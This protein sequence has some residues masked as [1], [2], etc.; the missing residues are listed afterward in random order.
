MFRKRTTLTTLLE[1]LPRWSANKNALRAAS[2]SRSFICGGRPEIVSFLQRTSWLKLQSTQAEQPSNRP[3][4][5]KIIKDF[6]R[7]DLTLVTRKLSTAAYWRKILDS[8][9][10]EMGLAALQ[11]T[12]SWIA[13]Y[14]AIE[15]ALTSFVRCIRRPHDP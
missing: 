10:I 9:A 11:T 2:I 4:L 7:R 8:P 13:L 3:L 14:P 5:H 12:T 6:N 15:G 1:G